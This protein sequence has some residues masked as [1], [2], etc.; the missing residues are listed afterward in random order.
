MLRIL[1]QNV[2]RKGNFM[3]DVQKQSQASEHT[4]YA[5]LG[6]KYPIDLTECK[7]YAINPQHHA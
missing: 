6:P 7:I 5:A 4:N 1:I 3:C 2:Q